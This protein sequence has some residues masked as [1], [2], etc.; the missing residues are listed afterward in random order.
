MHHRDQRYIDALVNNNQKQTAFYAGYYTGLSYLAANHTDAAIAE[1]KK[2]SDQSPDDLSQIK[3][4]WYL[5]L[6]YLKSGDTQ[7]AK[8]LRSNVSSAHKNAGYQLRAQKLLHALN[9]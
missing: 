6:A 5:A 3:T 1:L 4:Q 9:Q 7:V 8:E 2:A